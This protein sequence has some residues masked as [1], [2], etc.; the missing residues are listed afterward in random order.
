MIQQ[1][2]FIQACVVSAAVERLACSAWP[3]LRP[4]APAQLGSLFFYPVT[5]LSSAAPLQLSH[6]PPPV[7]PRKPLTRAGVVCMLALRTDVPS[8][9][10][11]SSA[12]KGRLSVWNA[13]NAATLSGFPVSNVLNA[14]V[15]LF[16]LAPFSS[17]CF[18]TSF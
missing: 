4:T 18:S 10:S 14:A 16:L 3:H 17:H 6:L 11:L 7:P 1:Y 12:P 9:A 13:V 8:A 15:T 2:A 5:F